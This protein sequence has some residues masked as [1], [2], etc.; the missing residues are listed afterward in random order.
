MDRRWCGYCR[1]FVLRWPGLIIRRAPRNR[2]RSVAD[3]VVWHCAL[4][5]E[6]A[7]VLSKLE[8]YPGPQ[9]AIVRYSAAHSVFDD[10]VYNA[11]DID[12]AHVVW[13]REMDGPDNAELLRYFRGSRVW[14]VEPDSPRPKISPYNSVA[15]G[16][17]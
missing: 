9:L 6:R 3:H 4:G 15:S 16:T 8:S 11:A 17:R 14:L 10:W 5:L 7:R 1:Y 2:H 12:H 13:A